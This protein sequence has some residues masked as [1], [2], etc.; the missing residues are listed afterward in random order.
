[1]IDRLDHF[2][3]TVTS[4]EETC[5]FYEKVLCMKV[6][7]FGEGRKALK[8]GN[9]KINLHEAGKE[10]EPKA[11]K[12][13][14]G[15]GD[16]CLITNLPISDVVAHLNQCSVEIEDGPIARTGAIGNIISV[17]F[18]DPDLNLVEVS[19]YD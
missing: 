4:I 2:V 16:F 7:T 17:Y 5:A 6:E 1:M 19:R 10:F 9:Q 3:L 8:F 13:T 14:R 11:E 15:A 12:P 18:R